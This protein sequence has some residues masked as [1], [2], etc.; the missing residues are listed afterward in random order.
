ME[1]KPFFWR[2]F[3]GDV[4]ITCLNVFNF[5]QGSDG[6]KTLPLKEGDVTVI[7]IE[8]SAEDGT[9]KI[10][11]IHA[12]RLSAKDASLTA[13]Q[14]STGA[15]QPEFSSDILEYTSKCSYN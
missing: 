7:K 9:T 2:N 3:E 14:L 5:T 1:V 4:I 11:Q 6:S 10:Y 12:K 13:I 15:L 8:V